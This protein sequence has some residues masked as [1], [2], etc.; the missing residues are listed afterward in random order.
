M[1]HMLISKITIIKTREIESIKININ[2]SLIMYLSYGREPSLDG[3]G[4]LFFVVSRRMLMIS[5]V[6]INIFI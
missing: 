6:S 1:L 2:G 5:P 4:S 3:G